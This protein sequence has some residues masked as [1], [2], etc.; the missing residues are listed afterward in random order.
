VSSIGQSLQP[1][2]FGTQPL[3]IRSLAI[4]V[5]PHLMVVPGNRRIDVANVLGNLLVVLPYLLVVAIYG[6]SLLRL[7]LAKLAFELR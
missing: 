7:K 4:V 2:D 6:L 1:S 3:L 5:S